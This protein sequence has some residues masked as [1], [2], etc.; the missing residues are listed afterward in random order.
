MTA[1]PTR[2]DDA[3][4]NH[5][6]FFALLGRLGPL[7]VIHQSG[8]ST[9]EALCTFGP[10]GFAQGYMN[11]ITDAYHWHLKLDGF[12]HVRSRDRTHARSGRRVLFFELAS[13]AGAK[14][15]TSI[16]LH[17]AKG[18]DFDPEVQALFAR[19]HQTLA[20]GCVLEPEETG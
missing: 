14:P 12:G 8:A 1:A 11:A 10:H 6:R 2:A 19:A 18:A 9:F 15:F 5:R 4:W 7:R 3:A 13:D 16:Y 20:D 17:R